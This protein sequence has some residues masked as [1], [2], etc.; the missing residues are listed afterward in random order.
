VRTAWRMLE[1]LQFLAMQSALRSRKPGQYSLE[2]VQ[3]SAVLPLFLA[4]N[5]FQH[6]KHRERA[7]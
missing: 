6:F 2:S 5:G 3:R 4:F 7:I 1:A